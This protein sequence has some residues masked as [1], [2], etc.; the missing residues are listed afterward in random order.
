M[1]KWI[2]L[3][4]RGFEAWSTYRLYDTL[5][6]KKAQVVD[7]YP[8]FRYTYPG[9]E[10]SLNEENMTSA[11]NSIEGDDLTSRVFWDIN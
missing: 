4:N 5:P 6:M 1:Q 3:Y 7:L 2:A 9:S 11:S 8:P 10:Y